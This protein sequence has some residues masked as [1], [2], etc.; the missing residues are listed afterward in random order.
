VLMSG[1]SDTE[2]PTSGVVVNGEV[3]DVWEV[4]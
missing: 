4:S 3:A 2:V 1:A